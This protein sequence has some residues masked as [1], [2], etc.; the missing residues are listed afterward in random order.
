MKKYVVE[1]TLTGEGIIIADCEE[2][3]HQIIKKALEES[4]DTI[5]KELAEKSELVHVSAS[6]LHTL[7]IIKERD[8]Q[9]D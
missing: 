4:A 1:F 5:G 3:A 6:H 2:E 8:P 9:P 7:R